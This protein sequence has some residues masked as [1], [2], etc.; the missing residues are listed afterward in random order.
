MA[1][2]VAATAAVVGTGAS[3]APAFTNAPVGSQASATLVSPTIGLG[4][5][6]SC[7]GSA[8]NGTVAE[9]AGPAAGGAFDFSQV[10]YSGC[11]MFGSRVT[12]TANGTPWRWS[13]NASGTATGPMDFSLAWG[14]LT[15][16]YAGTISG[17]YTQSTGNL[18]LSGSVTRISGSSLM[19]STAAI[20]GTY[21]V[22]NSANVPVQL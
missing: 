15:A 9:D 2:V 14:S 21:N 11:Q 18:V 6:M 22:R 16:H 10:T 1:A 13:V 12:W 19:P 3:S 7:T 20:Q 17:V 8:M 5:F 4:S